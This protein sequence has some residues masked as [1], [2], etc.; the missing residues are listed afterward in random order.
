M[1]VGWQGSSSRLSDPYSGFLWGSIWGTSPLHRGCGCSS[2]LA[3]AGRG[4]AETAPVCELAGFSPSAAFMLAALGSAAAPGAP[5]GA[6]E[7]PCSDAR[8][9][10]MSV[11]TLTAFCKER[12][13]V[14]ITAFNNKQ[15]WEKS[16]GLVL[17]DMQPDMYSCIRYEKEPSIRTFHLALAKFFSICAQTPSLMFLSEAALPEI[18]NNWQ[19][20]TTLVGYFCLFICKFASAKKKKKS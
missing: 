2:C 7:S 8:S 13:C 6:A 10:F 12:R 11:V 5:A 19:R 9:L 1:L 4:R 14:Y 15:K 17:E 16:S 3:A 20:T 18:L